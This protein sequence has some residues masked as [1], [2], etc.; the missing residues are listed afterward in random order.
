MPAGKLSG[1]LE[2]GH[3]P[4]NRRHRQLR[5]LV[6]T[7][8]FVQE[9]LQLI[10]AQTWMLCPEGNDLLPMPAVVLTLAESVWFSGSWSETAQ[11]ALV[12]FEPLFPGKHRTS[13]NGEGPSSR[14]GSIVV[15]ERHDLEPM[16]NSM[17][18]WMVGYVLDIHCFP[19]ITHYKAFQ[20]V[21]RLTHS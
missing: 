13:A 6:S 1:G 3:Q 14:F 2:L 18:V 19:S 8:A 9:Y 21:D 16:L 11:A 20:Q 12:S 10:F 7:T 4:A 15:I 17:F 5:V